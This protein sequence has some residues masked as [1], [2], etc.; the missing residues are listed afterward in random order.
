MSRQARETERWCY[1]F[2]APTLILAALF[3]FWP[4][5]ASWYYS[6]LDWSGYTADR[7]FVGLDNYRELFADPFFWQAFGRSFLFMVVAV[8]IRLG[9]ALLVAIVLNNQALKLSPVFRTFFFIPVVTTT[10]I[11][12][13]LMTFLLSPVNG[14]VNQMLLSFGLADTPVSFLGNPDSA[15]WTVV[16]VSVWKYFGISLVYW[17]AALQSIPAELYE[18]AKVDGASGWQRHR[19]ITA[20][21]LKPFAVIIVLITAVNTLRIFDL[22]YTM[23]QGGPYFATEVMEI[24]IYRNAFSV[25]GGGMPRL[26]FASAAGVL[27]GVA[28]LVIALGQGWAARRIALMRRDVTV[29]ERT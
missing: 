13:L 16:G 14:P 29:Q 15:F 1:L 27:F 5:I 4:I 17:L 22:V 20:P 3:T 8:P 23:T 2:M 18:A 6:V 19:D 7:T 21:L 26:G 12:G 25:L 24:Y 9:L 10:A 11:V 28:V